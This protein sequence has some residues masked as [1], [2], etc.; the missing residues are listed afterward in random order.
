MIELPEAMVLS[1][2]IQQSLTGRMITQA[3]ANQSP[4]KFAW[5]T[6]DP[7]GYNQ[8]L[9]GKTI[10]GAEALGCHV[11]VHA[12]DTRLAFTT[13]LRLHPAGSPL[14][15]KHQ[16][17][18]ALDDG[19]HLSAV[20]QMWGALLCLLEGVDEGLPDYEIALRKPGA[21]SPDFTRAYFDQLLE[22]CAPVLSVKA[23][24]ATEQ[25]IPGLG[26]GVLQ[27]ILYN[28][29]LHPRKK[30]G[31]LPPAARD[32]LFRAV[33]QTLGDMTAQGGRDTEPD[34]YGQPGGYVCLQTK[35]AAGALCPGCGG[36]FRKEAYMGGNVVF[37]PTCQPL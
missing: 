8:R 18:L 7:A 16:L 30:I 1:D 20:V 35:S 17:L 15:A 19:S 33:V 12:G 27:D 9:Q 3:A 36:P 13:R 26:N 25:R 24:L 5:Y 21:L 6:G 28:A 11:V 37:C 32:D 14:P 10:T 23:F 22:A 29:R 34:L 4:H 2:Q 31:E